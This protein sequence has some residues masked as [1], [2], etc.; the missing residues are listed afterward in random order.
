MMAYWTYQVD[1]TNFNMAEMLAVVFDHGGEIALQPRDGEK[2]IV[3]GDVVY[4]CEDAALH[5]AGVLGRAEVLTKPA[6][7]EMPHWQERFWYGEAS[8]QRVLP[9][10]RM[11]VT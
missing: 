11:R 8:D 3:I 9:R 4:L 5:D 2:H 10:V 6:Y 1:P 7:I